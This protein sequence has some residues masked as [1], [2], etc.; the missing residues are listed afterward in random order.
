[1]SSIE[2]W[3]FSVQGRRWKKSA[4][5]KQTRTY[6]IE[7]RFFHSGP[8][9]LCCV[10]RTWLDS[11]N[12][13]SMPQFSRFSRHIIL[14][15]YIHRFFFDWQ[16]ETD[17]NTSE[18]VSEFLNT[19]KKFFLMFWISS[20]SRASYTTQNSAASENVNDG[21]KKDRN[22]RV[23]DDIQPAEKKPVLERNQK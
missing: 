3:A 13:Y 19:W 4:G 12:F 5:G 1:M 20:T 2:F 8:I 23:D 10:S 18:R 22:R 17:K 14:K 15:S 7:L 16:F 11:K 6:P 9:F 21:T